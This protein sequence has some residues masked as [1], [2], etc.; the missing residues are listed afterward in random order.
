MEDLPL[1]ANLMKDVGYAKCCRHWLAVFALPGEVLD[2]A[3]NT[4]FAVGDDLELDEFTLCIEEVGKGIVKVAA[5]GLGTGIF[6]R[7]NEVIKHD[8]ARIKAGHRLLSVGRG[9]TFVLQIRDLLFGAA[10]GESIEAYGPGQCGDCDCS[11]QS[12]DFLHFSLPQLSF[13]V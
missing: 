3:G 5:H 6:E 4:Q 9:N 12:S 8:V 10:R 11:E 2:A 13:P 7:R 1:A